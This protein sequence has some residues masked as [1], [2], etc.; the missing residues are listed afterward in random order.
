[1]QNRVIKTTPMSQLMDRVARNVLIRSTDEEWLSIVEEAQKMGA[2]SAT[3]MSLGNLVAFNGAASQYSG[4]VR[5][6]L[7]S[8]K[9]NQFQ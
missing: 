5:E 7:D 3:D 9:P 8:L 1:M 6:F 4:T 2:L